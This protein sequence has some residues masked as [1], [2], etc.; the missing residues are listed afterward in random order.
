ME[1][2]A[3]LGHPRFFPCLYNSIF[4]DACQAILTQKEKKI[5]IFLLNGFL[6]SYKYV[7]RGFINKAPCSLYST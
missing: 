3:D 5:I 1:L 2:P 6:L 4:N 7:I